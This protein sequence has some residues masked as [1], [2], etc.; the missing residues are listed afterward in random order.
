VDQEHRGDAASIIE[1][2]ERLAALEKITGAGSLP[3]GLAL[4]VVPK[5]KEVKDLQPFIDALRDAPKRIETTAKTTYVPSFIDYVNR[6]KT[7]DSAIFVNGDVSAPQLLGVVDY[8]GQGASAAPRFGKHRV[9]YGF[10]LS[11]QIKAWSAIS[12]KALD[13]TEFATFLQDRQYDIANPP[14]DWMQVEPKTLD[15]MF[16][17]LNIEADQGQVDDGAPDSPAP[18]G[19]T[20]EGDDRY[21]PR[22]ALYK[23][24]KIRFGSSARLMQMARTIEVAVNA[25]AAEGYSPKTG[26]RTVTFTEEHTTHDGQGR[27]IT[28]PDM[29]L[30]KVPVWEAETAQLIPVRLQYRKV[31]A[32]L[33]W[34]LTLVEWKR[35]VLM[36]IKAEAERVKEATLLPIIYGAP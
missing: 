36:A 16:A 35:V 18:A 34:G 2:V 14:L 8:H 30:L 29:F 4:A 27:R 22:S 31:G 19:D 12:G 28:V 25:K 11:E 13:H 17:L 9:T 15:V 3:E 10:P 24:R 32:G 26:E 5:G 7:P 6:F 23:L 1:N 33:K 21:V 20:D